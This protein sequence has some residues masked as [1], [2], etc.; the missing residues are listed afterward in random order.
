MEP[1]D[2]VPRALND[3]PCSP[4]SPAAMA[5]A[6]CDRASIRPSNRVDRQANIRDLPSAGYEARD[7]PSERMNDALKKM[8]S[9]PNETQNANKPP[10][11]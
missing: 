10:K 2:E 1:H 11:K 9:T 6:A 7:D 5:A 8:M 4:T 3:T